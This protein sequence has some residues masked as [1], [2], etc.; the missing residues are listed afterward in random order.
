MEKDALCGRPFSLFNFVVIIM[1]PIYCPMCHRKVMGIG[2][3]DISAKEA[4]C[5][6]CK[7]L[8]IYNPATGK[9]KV[10]EIPPRQTSSGMRFY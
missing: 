4:K 6:N 3:F 7:K 10:A 2:E 9:C 1:I 5:D 8:I